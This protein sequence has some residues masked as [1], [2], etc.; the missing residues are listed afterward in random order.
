MAVT[1][2]NGVKM[3]LSNRL[4]EDFKKALKNGEKGAVSVIRMIKAA[5]KNKEI[6]KGSPLGDEEICGV[7][8]S[9]AR[10]GKDSEDQFIK[11]GRNDLAEKEARELL[12]IQSYLPRQLSEQEFKEIIGEVIKES[13]AGGPGDMGKV[14]KLIMPKIKG[15]A[16][17]KLVSEL[18]KKA[19]V[20]GSSTAC[21]EE[22]GK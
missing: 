19:L 2:S 20:N 22:E 14:M 11:G 7:L 16:D 1:F 10:Q 17:G 9:L 15:Q 21:N 3:S 12:I 18:A 13:G 6:E 5:I 8:M 4:S